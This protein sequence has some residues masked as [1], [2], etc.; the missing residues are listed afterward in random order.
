MI[1][2]FSSN[3]KK[4]KNTALQIKTLNKPRNSGLN[5]L[6]QILTMKLLIT[7]HLA[8]TRSHFPRI[9]KIVQKLLAHL[10]LASLLLEQFI[11]VFASTTQAA[12]LPITPD[13]STNTQV[14]QTASLQEEIQEDTSTLN[15]N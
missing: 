12:D 1:E 10:A 6:N 8:L 14:T 11:F 3:F 9:I 15:E 5:F 2:I 4:T 7:R 13:G